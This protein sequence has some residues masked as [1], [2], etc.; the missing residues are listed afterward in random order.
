MRVLASTRALNV[1]VAPSL[2]VAMVESLGELL[3][4]CKYVSRQLPLTEETRA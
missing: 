1:D 2:E 3:P 4:K